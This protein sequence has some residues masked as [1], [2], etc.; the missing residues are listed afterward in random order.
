MKEGDMVRVTDRA[1]TRSDTR[2]GLYYPYYANLTGRIFKLYGKG[3]TAEAAVEVDVETL[4]AD[5]AARHL[6]VSAQ[7]RKAATGAARNEEIPLRYVIL[8]SVMDLK[9]RTARTPGPERA[10]AAVA[11]PQPA[12][13]AAA[14]PAG[15]KAAVSRPARRA[16]GTP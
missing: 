4:P 6:E 13:S 5:I 9:R 2:S 3:D 14:L 1:A 16:P 15:G 10:T 11:P 7:M 8:T 12:R